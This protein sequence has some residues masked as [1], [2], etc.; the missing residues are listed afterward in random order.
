MKRKEKIQIEVELPS[1]ALH[2]EHASCPNGHQLIDESVKIHGK[3]AI[4]VKVRYKGKVGHL[5]I[6]P[7]YGSYDNIE[8]GVSV[9]RGGVYDIYCPEC[10]V[11]LKEAGELCQVCSS[12]LFVLELPHGGI[13]EACQK[14]GCAFHKMKIVDTE[15]Q[16]ARLFE[17]D[18]L[19]SFL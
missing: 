12:P 17:N 10:D 8:E 4:K 13:V 2:V 3:A 7:V 1:D 18:T 11:S 15:Q 5:F 14:K 9:T 16:V 19:E 6:D